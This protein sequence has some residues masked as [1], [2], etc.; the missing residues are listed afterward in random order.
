M[1]RKFNRK[2]AIEESKFLAMVIF[3]MGAIICIG[4]AIQRLA[5]I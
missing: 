3:V 2:R 1:K 5:A 4:L